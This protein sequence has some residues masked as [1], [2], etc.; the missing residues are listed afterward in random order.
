[1]ANHRVI[2][3]KGMMLWGNFNY[4]YGQNTMGYVSGSDIS[5]MYYGNRGWTAPRSVGYMESHD[6]E[7]EMYRNLQFGNILGSYSVKDLS[8]ALHRMK[9][10]AVM[11]YTI[12]GPKM[13]WQFGELGY[14][15][16]INTCQDGSVNSNCR[17]DPKPLPWTYLQDPNRKSLSDHISNLL[18]LRKNYSV[19]TTTGVAQITS[20]SSFLV[21]QMTLKNT[22]YTSTP[23]DS[24][25]MNVQVAANLDVASQQVSIIFPHAG[26]WYDYYNNN[27]PVTG[28]LVALTMAPG[29]YKLYTDVPIKGT[30]LV[31]EVKN[32]FDV[33]INL[34]PNPTLGQ[35]HV[36]TDESIIDLRVMSVTGALL[37]PY[38]VDDTSWDFSSL[39]PGLYIVEIRTEHGL[40]RKKLVVSK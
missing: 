15:K 23:T 40:S 17:L 1:L 29:D 13:I 37:T 7:R 39:S 19:F 9:T 32:L 20:G 25:Q 33:Q 36:D 30:H 3:G 24:T 6:E 12:P 34:Y 4:A 16:S 31:T 26:T 2:E 38:R 11:F 35:L 8:T 10:T 18:S 27:T 22:P 14:D 5:G 28:S 21:Q